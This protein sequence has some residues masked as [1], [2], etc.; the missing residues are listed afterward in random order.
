MSYFGDYQRKSIAPGYVDK[1]GD[2]ELVIIGVRTG[3]ID[4]EDGKKRYTQVDCEINYGER[5]HIAIF[6][7]EGKAFDGQFTAFCDTFG[8]DPTERSFNAWKGKSGYVHILL[9][10]K[11]GFTN[12]VPRWI[13]EN[14]YVMEEVKRAA[15]GGLNKNP[16]QGMMRA[17]A[18]QQPSGNGNMG[19]DGTYSDDLGDIPF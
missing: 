10:Q 11:D 19:V 12:M 4:G 16:T 8:I 9:K 15:N 6:L 14:G 18:M 17:S 2:Y 1:E 5:P 3:E 7:T 13:L